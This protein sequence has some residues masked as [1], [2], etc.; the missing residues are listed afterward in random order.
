MQNHYI[1]R[2]K[3]KLNPLI[4]A[5]VIL[6]AL[7]LAKKVYIINQS[8]VIM[9]IIDYLEIP[10][11]LVCVYYV[12]AKK[13]YPLKFIGLGIVVSIIFMIVIYESGLA[14]LLKATILILSFKDSDF[15]RLAQAYFHT[16]ICM[17][18]MTIGLYILGIS[19]AGIGR[20]DYLTFGFAGAGALGQVCFYM[21]IQ[22]VLSGYTRKRDTKIIIFIVNCVCFV[23]CN[24]R[25]GIILGMITLLICNN[26]LT[27]VFIKKGIK[28]VMFILPLIL[29]GLTFITSLLYV[30]SPFVQNIDR[31][32][33]GRILLNYRNLGLFGIKLFGQKA[34][35]YTT[36]ISYYNEVTK[37]YSTF[38]TIDN[39]YMC[40]FITM[41]II[42]MIVLYVCYILLVKKCYKDI[43]VNLLG[44]IA[45]LCIYGLVE[46][47]IL[48]IYVSLPFY[49]LTA[50]KISP[51]VTAEVKKR[52]RRQYSHIKP[53]Y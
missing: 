39:A 49:Y 22:A 10:L 44:I 2:N 15:K 4:C 31:L 43:Q 32:L 6:Y 42:A 48:S 20:R 24:N 38:N 51:E 30:R 40:G 26:K 41:G 33:S 19:D 29:T 28:I 14:E 27:M 17:T 21:T 50:R 3:T 35:F 53:V 34:N 16:T 12:I 46:N 8:E 1:K 23:L 13:K 47:S 36:N 52:K 5:L 37:T 45:I 11:Y 9:K 18:L 7:F 25:S